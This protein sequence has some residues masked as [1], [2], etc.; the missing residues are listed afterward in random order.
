VESGENGLNLKYEFYNYLRY[1]ELNLFL[2]A[3]EGENGDFMAQFRWLHGGA[4][5]GFGSGRY[6]GMMHGRGDDL[7][8]GGNSNFT[9]CLLSK[10]I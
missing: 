8:L 6:D 7:F 1:L 2:L 9:K 4:I 3:V 10:S 5:V